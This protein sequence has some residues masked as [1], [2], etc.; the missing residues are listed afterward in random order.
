MVGQQTE[1]VFMQNQSYEGFFKKGNVRNF[2]EFTVKHLCRNP[3]FWCFLVNFG[4]FAKI[5]FFVEQHRATASDYSSIN[6]SKGSIGKR[7]CKL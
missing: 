2:A 7:S 5:P 4:K 3:L 1:R 6:S